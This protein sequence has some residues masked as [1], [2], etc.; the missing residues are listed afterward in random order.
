M[1]TLSS[2]EPDLAQI[3]LMKIR[4]KSS[5]ARETLRAEKSSSSPARYY[6]SWLTS[7]YMYVDSV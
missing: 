2:S 7:Q 6:S 3:R 5:R 4:V 1:Y